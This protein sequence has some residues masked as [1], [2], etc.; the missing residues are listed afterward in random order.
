VADVAVAVIFQQGWPGEIGRPGGGRPSP[1]PEEL[2]SPPV[3][4]REEKTADA[5]APRVG[6]RPREELDLIV[7]IPPELPKP[8]MASASDT[9]KESRRGSASSWWSRVTTSSGE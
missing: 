8:T 6:M 9:M 4:E 7:T 2:R 1:T 5:A 3:A